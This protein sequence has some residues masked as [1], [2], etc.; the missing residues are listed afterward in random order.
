MPRD[1]TV[2]IEDGRILFRNFAGKEGKYNRAGDRNFAVLLDDVI[3]K[4]LH[5][6]GWN[7]KWLKPRE[8]GDPLQAYLEIK[9]NYRGRPPRIVMITTRGRTPLSED[10]VELLDYADIKTVDMVLNPYEWEIGGKSGISAYLKSMFV[11]IH[12]DP[13]ELKY[14]DIEDI[15]SRS[16]RV[17]E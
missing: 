8:E 14:A 4:N 13:L 2:I 12:E 16:G 3:A 10:Q 7:V 1:N 9:V 15:P 5:E 17:D 11:T 6:D